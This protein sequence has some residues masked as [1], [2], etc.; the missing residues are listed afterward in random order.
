MG[1]WEPDAQ[2]R[3]R[4]AAMELYAEHGFEPT[5][6]ADIA[7]RA[8]VTERT[9]F[10]YFTDKREVLFSGSEQLQV[11]AMAA[12][13]GAPADTTPLA[14]VRVAVEAAVGVLQGDRDY[15]A[16]RARVVAENASLLERELLKLARLAAAMGDGLRARGVESATSD[17]AAEAGVAVFKLSF[18]RWVVD[19]ETRTLLEVTHES[20][21]LLRVLN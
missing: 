5:T 18:D 16:M 3:L 19:G 2:G 14:T 11:E 13:E 15:A 9:F 20:F 4:R 17:L 1:R 12:L 10:R 21:E 7:E 6:V 8:G